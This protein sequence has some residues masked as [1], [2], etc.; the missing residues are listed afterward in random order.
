MSYNLRNPIIIDLGSSE[1]KVG[2]FGNETPNICI[3]NI[4]GEPLS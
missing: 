4:I 3:Q 2:F 1:I